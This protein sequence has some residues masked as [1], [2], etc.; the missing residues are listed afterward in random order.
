MEL[1]IIEDLEGEIW[2]QLKEYPEY[3]FSNFGRMK[4]YRYRSHNAKNPSW[5][6]LNIK[7]NKKGYIYPTIH[8]KHI[9]LHRLIAKAFIPNEDNLPEVD[10]IDG[11]RSNNHVLNLRWV[12]SQQNMMNKKKYNNNKSGFRGICWHKRDKKWQVQITIN[13]KQIHGGC[14]DN[15]EDAIKRRIELEDMYWDKEFNPRYCRNQ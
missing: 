2:K 5:W 1:R 12:N 11:C 6:L 14:F 10:H 7:P 15:I 3:W 9:F 8:G 4:S 13:G